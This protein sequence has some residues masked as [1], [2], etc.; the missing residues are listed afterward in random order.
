MS[1]TRPD[2]RR[3][4]TRDFLERQSRE[5][6]QFLYDGVDKTTASRCPSCCGRR[7]DAIR[8]FKVQTN[9]YS[10]RTRPQFRRRG[11]RGLQVGHE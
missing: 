7:V 6:E 8:E 1:G 10:A 4:G 5:L 11:G 2:D 9:L 3:P